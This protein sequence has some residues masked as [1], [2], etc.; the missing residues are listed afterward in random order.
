MEKRV[1]VVLPNL[2]GAA[3]AVLLLASS[4]VHAQSTAPADEK[5]QEIEL[6][7]SQIKQLEGRVRSL[8][9]LAPKV[10]VIDR[11]VDAQE[12]TQLANIDA[13]R[14]KALEMPIIKA[15]E[16]GFR[17]ASPN[18]DYRIRFGGVLQ[19]NSRFF[20]S[21]DDKNISSTFYIN[22]ARPIISGA[23]GKY[24]EYQITPDFGQGKTILQDAWINFG[25]S[26]LAQLQAGKYKASVNLER[27]QADPYLEFIQRSEVQNLVPNRDIG[28]QLNGLLLDR[29]LNYQL[30][31]MNGVPNNTAS[32]DFDN[33]DAK[34]FIGR[35]FLTPFKKSEYEWLKGF[36]AGVA[37]TYGTESGNTTSVYKTWGQ[38]TWFN[39]NNGVTADGARER[40]DGQAYYYWRHLGLMAEYAQ[41]HHTLRM[42][43]KNANLTHSF[44]DN[45]YMAQISYYLTGENASY[46]QVAPL[47]PFDPLEFEGLGALSV[48]ARISNVATDTNQFRLGFAD[49]GVAAKTATEVAFGINW[50]LNNNVKYSVDYAD[51]FFRDG[52]STNGTV[53]DR[54][55]ESVFET[56][57]QIAF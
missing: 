34:D 15:S 46:G 23:V 9:E 1:A 4:A 36:G 16:Q 30:A 7:K 47:R 40:L 19:T 56:Q 29:R 41:D 26:A 45:G 33:N 49:P 3:F 44:T 55:A 20:T 31:L 27:L 24:F 22:K 32:S 13:E 12:E 18:D 39:Y 21:G 38:S 51:T 54:P 17:L 57:L 42:T 11:K 48:A 43:S 28:I 37:G 35:A 52:A 10:K 2:L 50:I 8:E 25:Y 6:L 53:T 14:A 5:D